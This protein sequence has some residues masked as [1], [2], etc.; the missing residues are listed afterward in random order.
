MDQRDHQQARIERFRPVVLREGVA[1]RI[2][3]L[4]A[5]LVVDLLAHPAPLIERALHAELLDRPHRPIH[6]Y[7]GH[8]PRVRELL[9]G[10]AHLPDSLV[11][12]LPVVDNELDEV[13]RQRPGLLVGA[14][15][16]L[17]REVQRIQYLAVDVEL[18]LCRRGVADAHRPRVLIAG[19]PIDL[20]LG[21]AA[22][23][24]WPVQGLEGGRIATRGAEQPIDEGT[25]LLRV[26]ADVQ[27]P[28]AERGVAHP[29]V[30]VVPVAD[31]ADLLWQ[32]RGGRGDDAAGGPEGHCLDHHQRAAN[33]VLPGTVVA[34]PR[35]PITPPHQR[36]LERAAGVGWLV[37]R[38][39]RW[40]PAEHERHGLALLDREVCRRMQALTVDGD[41]GPKADRVGT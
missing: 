6:G 16:E 12:V 26:A 32:G 8:H 31:A 2:E 30:A 38:Q 17:T 20:E 21:Q 36:P 24:G 15:R 25:R 9:A 27:R 23:T 14:D 28:Q 5:D 22:L 10:P 39:M 1:L 41:A 29:A 40:V 18:E 35:A 33:V 19:Q 11:R 7:P 4:L 13:A 37:R 34:Q 3:S